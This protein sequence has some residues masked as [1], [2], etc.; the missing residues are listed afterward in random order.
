MLD[1]K[2]L[3]ELRPSRPTTL[4]Q[5][6][7]FV[8]CLQRS[9]QK[10][11]R[12]YTAS[13][14]LLHSIAQVSAFATLARICTMPFY[15]PAI[16]RCQSDNQPLPR[17]SRLWTLSC[18][19]SAGLTPSWQTHM[20]PIWDPYRHLY[21]PHMG[22]PHGTHMGFANGIGMGPIWVFDM[23]PIWVPHGSHMG[24]IWVL[25]TGLAWVPYGYLI[26]DP[27]GSHVGPRLQAHMGPIWV[28]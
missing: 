25:Q 17:R 13:T 10:Q 28:P 7:F 22:F 15:S 27:Y 3:R 8:P 18:M 20:G 9:E 16:A 14:P 12:T 23:G 21:G 6:C 24:P 1:A 19:T 4:V 5:V 2:L 26:W 11:P